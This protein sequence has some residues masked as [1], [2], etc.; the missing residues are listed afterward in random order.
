M[1]AYSVMSSWVGRLL[2]ALAVPFLLALVLGASGAA[3]AQ[4]EAQ[5][6]RDTQA[7]RQQVQP[8]NNAPVWREVRKE[9]QEHYTSIKGRETGVLIQT[10]GETWRELRNGWIVPSVGWFLAAFACAVWLFYRWRGPIGLH[11]KPTGRLIQRFTVFQRAVHW[12]NAIL[13]CI[14][15]VSGLVMMLGKYLLLPVIGHTLFSWLADPLKFL[16]NFAGPVFA[17]SMLIMAVRFAKDAL[18][19]AHDLTWILKG[20]GIVTDAHVPCGKM[21]A[22]QKMWFWGG[23]VVL[24][25]TAVV[26]GLIM[27]FPNFDQTRSTMITVNVIHSVAAGLVI[28]LSLY[29][30]YMGTIGIEGAYEGMRHGYVDETYAKQHHSYWY[31]DIKAGK[32]K[33]ETAQGTPQAPQVAQVAQ[34]LHGVGERT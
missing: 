32:I 2:L 29:H 26:T 17:V 15:A 24:S 18:P 20:G 16:H 10:L 6:Q 14:L 27:D 33:I 30:I 28:A 25:G 3:L 21:N 22:G 4:Q 12:T 13:F 7:Q 9:G 31:D 11:D 34:G 8:G 5:A 19:S 23:L 1:G